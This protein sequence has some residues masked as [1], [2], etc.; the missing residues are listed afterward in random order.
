MSRGALSAGLLLLLVGL[1]GCTA[2]G[3]PAAQPDA[4]VAPTDTTT[5][6]STD[7]TTEDSPDAAPEEC[8]TAFPQAFTAP[9]LAEVDALP[10]DWPDP[11]EGSTLCLTSSGLGEA[12]IE[13]MSYATEAAEAAV[14]TYYEQA[15]AAYTVERTPSP[16]G[17]EM[18]AGDGGGIGFQVQPGEGSIVIVVQPAG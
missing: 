15:L 5:E 8:A 17:G 6:T 12:A 9:D 16:T 7:T 3:G 13:S 1:G 14:L 2:E 11:P 18:L 10:A 4:T